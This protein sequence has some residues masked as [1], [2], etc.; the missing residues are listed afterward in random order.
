MGV[1]FKNGNRSN[2]A[3]DGKT[4]ISTIRREATRMGRRKKPTHLKVIENSRDRRDPKLIAGEPMP[5]QPLE[6]APEHFSEKERET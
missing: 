1:R 3:V 4:L 5:S 2:L 6:H